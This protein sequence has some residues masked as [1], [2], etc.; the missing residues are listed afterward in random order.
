MDHHQ[1]HHHIQGN[2]SPS[3]MPRKRKASQPKQKSGVPLPVIQK[4]S[5]MS[6]MSMIGVPP[7]NDDP[8]AQ[9]TQKMNR[10]Y[11]RKRSMGPLYEDLQNVSLGSGV[12]DSTSETSCCSVVSSSLA[13]ANGELPPPPPPSARLPHRLVAKDCWPNQAP[14]TGRAQGRG[15][16]PHLPSDFA[17]K[18]IRRVEVDNN[19]TPS[20]TNFPQEV[21]QSVPVPVGGGHVHSHVHSGHS[22]GGGHS[23][24][25]SGHLVGG[26][27]THSHFDSSHLVGGGHVH[28]HVDSGHLVGGGHVHSHFD[29]G[30]L[31]G[32]GHAHSHV[33]SGHSVGGRHVHSHVDSGH[34][35]GGGHAHSHVDSSHSVGGRHVHSHVDSGHLVGGGHVQCNHSIGCG[36]LQSSYPIGGEL[37]QS[38]YSVVGG[39]VHRSHSI[40]GVTIQSSH[41]HPAEPT[42]EEKSKVFTFTT[43]KEPPVYPPGSQEE[44]WQL[45]ILGKGRVTCPKCKSVSRK[46]VDG[47]KKHMESCRL[48][49]FT[50]QQCGKQ[51]KSSTGMKYH[52][53]ADHNNLPSPDDIN[54]LDDQS[55]KEKLRKVLKRMGKLKCSKEGCTGSFTSIMGYLYHMKKCGK[56]ESE[57]EK[58]LLNCQ[59]CGKVY[60]SKA[61]LEY[62]LKSEH[63][64]VPQNAEEEEVKAQREP[65]PERTPSGRVK[66]M[67]AQVAFFHLQEI[68]ND[69]LAKEW[70]KRKVIGDLVPDDKKLRYARPGL[71]A[72]SQEVLRKWKNEVKLQKKVQCPNLGCGSVYTSVSGLK[73]HLGLCGRGDFEAGKYKCL[74]CKKEFNSE[75]G[76]K[77]HINSVHS[78]DWFVV[79]SK[80]KNF[81]KVLKTKPKVHSTVN[82]PTDQLQQQTLHVFT[83]ILEPWQDMQM[84]PPP[85]VPESALQVNPEAAEGKRRGKGRGKEKDCYDFTGSDHSSS[86]S[87]GSSSSGSETEEPE[88]QRHNVDQWALQRPSII[89][90]HPEAAK[91][92]RS[93]L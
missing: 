24:V 44:R 22:V 7:K 75:S 69:E 58:L 43:K 3:Y 49:P 29:S 37:V 36:H 39:H 74:I 35:V 71:P 80:S 62:H 13:V 40:G 60:K 25:Y 9:A 14:D 63:A 83:P 87:S 84:G 52:I 51:L 56:K 78:Q 90:T 21:R 2:K 93:N 81:D 27:H 73:A 30:H 88:G 6:V 12:E 4:M 53:M 28:S 15:Q 20:V 45:M 79:T 85:A 1:L 10:S 32:G 33:D 16:E 42:E 19:S 47:L 70:P 5:D 34:L 54:G 86:S 8:H 82:D 50:C 76:V 11:G 61:G 23:N 66:R 59:H 41:S 26:G 48:N 92:P 18:K 89:E 57:L 46:T 64:P 31:V 72:F 91:R 17:I 38:S 65:N 77:Y 67:S 55:M 68:A